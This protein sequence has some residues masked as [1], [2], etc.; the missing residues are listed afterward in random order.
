MLFTKEIFREHSFLNIHHHL[1]VQNKSNLIFFS[2]SNIEYTFV[3][4]SE[5]I[6][7]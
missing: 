1:T 5:S 2:V 3:K 4:H 7:C 6:D